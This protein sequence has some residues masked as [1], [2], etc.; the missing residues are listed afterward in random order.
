MYTNE[1]AHYLGGLDRKARSRFV[2][3]L[4]IEVIRK[5]GAFRFLEGTIT[6][7]KFKGSWEDDNLLFPGAMLV[8]GRVVDSIQEKRSGSLAQGW[9]PQ[10]MMG[11]WGTSGRIPEFNQIAIVILARAKAMEASASIVCCLR[12]PWNYPG[13][14]PM[15][16]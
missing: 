6:Y 5:G 14:G 1:L 15:F 9:A 12:Y 3:F 2:F 4:M 10:Q 16:I 13:S 7:P 11:A 8:S